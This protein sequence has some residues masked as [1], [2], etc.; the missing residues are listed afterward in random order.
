MSES[1]YK[2][3]L[4]VATINR[5]AELEKLFKSLKNQTFTHFEVILVDQNKN[6]LIKNLVNIYSNYFCILHIKSEVGLSKARNLGIKHFTGDIVAFPDDD[7]WY[8][9]CLLE[10]INKYFYDNPDYVGITGICLDENN[11]PL[12]K[13][14][15]KKIIQLTKKNV[16]GQSKSVTIFLRDKVI[17]DIGNFDEQLGV[18]ANTYVGSG[19]E[20]D[21][22]IRVLDK[23]YH[24]CHIPNI[25]IHHPRI[26]KSYR[27]INKLLLYTRGSGFLFRKYNYY[28]LFLYQ[29]IKSLVG[30]VYFFF[31]FKSEKAKYHCYSFK[32]KWQ[33]FFCTKI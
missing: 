17:F 8:P 6:D 5:V 23:G 3:S 20:A 18:G 28:D 10:D 15:Y 7:C 29:L 19:E 32:G 9:E 22:M 1:K 26:I 12:D 14:R 31:T 4:I 2:I 25:I 27:D 30:I 21:Y 13:V 24:V 16:W 33:G 11:I